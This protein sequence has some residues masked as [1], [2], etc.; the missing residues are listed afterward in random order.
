M[1]ATSDAALDQAPGTTRRRPSFHT[2]TV[3]EVRRLT[4]DAVEIAFR[5]PA[6]LAGH[7][8]YLPGQYV[9]VRIE[10]PDEDG[11][12]REIRRSYSICAEPRTFEDGT[13][14][15]RVAVKK[16]IGGVFSTWANTDLTAGITWTS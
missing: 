9:A 2:L 11:V 12:P 8:D 7:F 10:L 13:G 1:S 15:I 6:D 16:D 5:V 3:K 14:E 4:Q